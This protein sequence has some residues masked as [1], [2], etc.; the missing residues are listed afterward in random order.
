MPDKELKQVE[1]LKKYGLFSNV[2]SFNQTIYQNKTKKARGDGYYYKLNTVV[3]RVIYDY[4][5]ICDDTIFLVEKGGTIELLA[6][7]A[8]GEEG[9][10]YHRKLNKKSRNFIIPKGLFVE[11]ESTDY[12]A[13][14]IFVPSHS[15][16]LVSFH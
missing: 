12:V 11:D 2:I 8:P 10:V 3:P 16:V 6:H 14:F 15:K 7:V 9:T 13:T 4:L 1:I 5:E